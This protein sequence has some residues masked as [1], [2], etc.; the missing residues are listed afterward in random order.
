MNSWQLFRHVLAPK[1]AFN[2]PVFLRE[3]RQA[4]LWHAAARWVAQL[5]HFQVG[6]M[7]AGGIAFVIVLLA[8]NNLLVVLLPPL[9]LL[10]LGTGLTIGP[11]IALERSR[12]SWELL[13]T[14]PAGL[15]AVLTAKVS[16][17]LSWLRNLMFIMGGL[18]VVVALG[19]GVFSLVLIPNHL[20]RASSQSLVALCGITLM[21]PLGMGLLFIVDRIQHYLLLITAALAASSL[22]TSVPVA[23]AA[24]NAAIAFVW[25]LEIVTTTVVVTLQADGAQALHKSNLLA[26]TT[27]GPTISY[28]LTLDLGRV[29]LA[30]L[31]TLAA[32]EA[33][34]IGLWRVA[35]YNAGR[36]QQLGGEG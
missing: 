30:M 27:L 5:T 10:C 34:L 16:G 19:I 29:L 4:P 6:L 11:I 25:L 22:S 13:L 2:D 8:V 12:Q 15:E 23:V 35:V 14:I 7:L 26:L 3:A 21:V 33:L 32:R 9:A 28:I 24:A 20:A 31:G 36:E 1:D 17:A 18:L